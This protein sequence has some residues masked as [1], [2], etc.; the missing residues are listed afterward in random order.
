[1]IFVC[2][3]S[4]E[5]RED[6]ISEQT[7]GENVFERSTDYDPAIDGIV[8]SHALR[9]RHR[10][11]EFFAQPEEARAPITLT[12]PR[13]A[14][15]PVFS[16]RSLPEVPQAAPIDLEASSPEVP[17]GLQLSLGNTR[18]AE[19]SDVQEPSFIRRVMRRRAVS[20]VAY[21][22][23]VLALIWVV[24]TCAYLATHPGQ[25]ERVKSAILGSSHPLWRRL[26]QSD[27]TT[28]IVTADSSLVVI[29]NLSQNYIALSD[30]VSGAYRWKL[31]NNSK[32]PLP[33][34]EDLASRRYTSI[35]DLQTL[36]R[37]L[38]LPGIRVDQIQVKYAR[39]VHP[40]DLKNGNV[41]LL[42]A[43]ES[44]PWVRLYEPRMNFYFVNDPNTGKFLIANRNP[45]EQEKATYDYDPADP[46]HKVYAV[47]AF[48]PA[49]S[50][51]GDTLIL[52]G[53]TM[54]GTEAAADFVF[55][56]SYLLP[57][58]ARIKLSDG[59]IPHFEVLLGSKSTGG[60]ASQLEV[61]AYR[62]E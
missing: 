2:R 5:G 17:A 43:S 21:G 60:N 45:Q 54:A 34:L 55:T 46:E 29:E 6:E 58:L 7:I 20:A 22:F 48:Q 27:R 8:R 11:E 53:Q 42:G 9:L 38:R 25:F 1:L 26:F 36:D 18:G 44:T 13:G 56:D 50:G 3:L 52:E 57:F 62:V 23:T 47:V 4:L 30:Y 19:S 35:I 41:V 24:T 31:S 16:V 32:L 61:L 14:Y 15:V 28:L 39:D 33:V 59:S 12:I 37:F 49:L 51:S 40:N 10:L